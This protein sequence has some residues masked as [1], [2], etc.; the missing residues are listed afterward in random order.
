[1]KSH[2]SQLLNYDCYANLQM[3]NLISQW[4]EIMQPVKLMAHLLS[5]Q[6]RWLSRCK[7]EP[8]PATSLWPDWPA[9]EFAQII[10]SNNLDWITY[11]DHLQPEEFNST[12]TYQNTLG[13]NFSDQ[14]A[15][16]LAHL[17]NHGTHHRAQIG[18]LLKLAGASLP[19][20]DYIFYLR[21]LNK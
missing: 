18:Q 9:N 21:Q 7:F 15:D 13:E 6:Q 19:Q 16:V 4:P 14:L 17:V 2:F 3:N 1:M 11:L 12:I 10:K 8:A 5:A 20:T